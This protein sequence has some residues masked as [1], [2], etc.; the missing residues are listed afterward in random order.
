M[1][2]DF[3]MTSQCNMNCRYCFGTRL[4]A[5]R[6]RKQLLSFF[7]KAREADCKS[8]VFTG[9]EPTLD[10][11]FPDYVRGLK[12]MG[13]HLVLST[14]GTFWK[15][16]ELKELIMTSFDCVALPLDSSA[17]QVHNAMRQGLDDH[18]TLILDVCE[19]LSRGERQG[20]K[21]KIGTVVSKENIHTLDSLMDILPVAPDIWKLYQLAHGS[22][23]E[24]YY[25]ANRIPD[26]EFLTKVQQLK[27]QNRCAKTQIAYSLEHDRDGKYLFLEPDGS[28][29]TIQDNQEVRIGN[30]YSEFSSILDAVDKRIDHQK[31]KENYTISFMGIEHAET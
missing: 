10:P 16:D 5:Q 19:E 20:P 8:I 13:Y 28:L 25:L 22:A 1:A 30:V 7:E 18:H 6:D 26:E 4:P 11:D 24:A 2:I 12:N 31:L 17:P 9:G 3:R 21:L 14:N 23:N 27:E 29:L 15:H